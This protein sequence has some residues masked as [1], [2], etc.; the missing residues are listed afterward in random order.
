MPSRKPLIAVAALLLILGAGAAA[1]F[2]RPAP[3]PPRAA[4]S[5]LP[6]P[7]EPEAPPAALPADPVETR[8][9]LP[10][11]ESDELTFGDMMDI[12]GVESAKPEVAPVAEKFAEKFMA[13]P[14]TRDTYREFK[15]ARARGDEPAAATFM[16]VL[17]KMPEFKA[18]TTQF[19]QQAGTSQALMA[20]AKNPTLKKFLVEQKNLLKAQATMASNRDRRAAVSGETARRGG[21]AAYASG[22]AGFGANAS[23]TGAAGDRA[24]TGFSAGGAGA[25]SRVGGG[26]A[27]I[28]ASGE[29]GPS[30]GGPGGGG[31]KAGADVTDVACKSLADPKCAIK[32]VGNDSVGVMDDAVKEWMAKYGIGSVWDSI[33]QDGL[34]GGC[35]KQGKLSACVSAC[36]NPPDRIKTMGKLYC[37]LPSTYRN[38]PYFAACME[39]FGNE[40]DCIKRCKQQSPC[41]NDPEVVRKLCAPPADLRRVKPN[42]TVAEFDFAPYCSTQP[43]YLKNK[44]YCDGGGLKPANLAAAPKAEADPRYPCAD[45]NTTN[46]KVAID[47]K[48]FDGEFKPGSPEEAQWL[49]TWRRD[50]RSGE[51]LKDFVQRRWVEEHNQDLKDPGWRCGPSS[52]YPSSYCD[53]HPEEGQQYRQRLETLTEAQRNALRLQDAQRREQEARDKKDLPPGEDAERASLIARCEK[54]PRFSK[55][56]EIGYNP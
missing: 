1:Y 56:A 37:R 32:T 25:S 8:D 50:G 38:Y 27:A 30:F 43:E 52:G 47:C 55:C 11:A 39:A 29:G 45:E 36:S 23:G 19:A 35:F 31:D 49:D 7:V 51:S 54:D 34:W 44:D 9:R 16:A 53:S 41:Q 22:Q 6:P 15:Q 18:M 26:Q 12:L 17:R 14:R 40:L 33:E 2:L 28:S 21:G 4:V 10:K 5:S 42:C 48:K 3:E 46:Q 13:N 20:L 24:S